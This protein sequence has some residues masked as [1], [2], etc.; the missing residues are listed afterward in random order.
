M[1]LQYF[2]ISRCKEHGCTAARQDRLRWTSRVT[3]RVCSAG[4]QLHGQSEHQLCS[5]N[6]GV[7]SLGS[8]PLLSIK[9]IIAL[10]TLYRHACAQRKR[11]RAPDLSCSGEPGHSSACLRKDVTLP[12]VKEDYT[13]DGALEGIERIGC[14]NRGRGKDLLRKS[15]C[16]AVEASGRTVF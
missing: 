10:V 8:L 14:T 7:P 11:E 6:V 9:G 3:Q 16:K 12:R 15:V 1:E 4:A 5:H 2:W 13:E